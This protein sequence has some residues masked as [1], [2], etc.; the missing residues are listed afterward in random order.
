MLV[1]RNETGIVV[2]IFDWVSSYYGLTW[3]K[4][5]VVIQSQSGKEK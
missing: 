2:K 4:K 3:L 1:S 5:G